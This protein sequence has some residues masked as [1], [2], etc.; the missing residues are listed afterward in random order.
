MGLTRQATRWRIAVFVQHRQEGAAMNVPTGIIR[1]YRKGKVTVAVRPDE[2]N[3]HK[4][5]G[6][7][8]D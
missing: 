4:P 8:K 5:K 6:A 7:R 2:G 3:E 1:D